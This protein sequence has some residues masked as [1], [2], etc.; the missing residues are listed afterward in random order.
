MH[1]FTVHDAHP[2]VLVDRRCFDILSSRL[3][4]YSFRLQHS[5]IASIDLLERR[6]ALRIVGAGVKKKVG[7]IGLEQ[8]LIGHLRGEQS[9]ADD[10]HYENKGVTRHALPPVVHPAKLSFLGGF[11]TED[12]T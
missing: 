3:A 7:R 2:P 4:A 10:H 12:S 9:G 5:Y 11:Y 8:I 6:M 1:G